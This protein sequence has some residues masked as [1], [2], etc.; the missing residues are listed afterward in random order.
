MLRGFHQNYSHPVFR[1]F[2]VTEYNFTISV[3]QF[4]LFR[5][6]E[7]VLVLYNLILRVLCF[8][9]HVTCIYSNTIGRH[10]VFS[11]K[12]NLTFFSEKGLKWKF[13]PISRYLFETQLG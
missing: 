13:C 9:A 6:L 3:N 4:A 10:E 5:Y 1:L 7:T 11:K 12:L 2:I 8:N